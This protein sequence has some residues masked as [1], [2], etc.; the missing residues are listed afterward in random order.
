MEE[1]TNKT[2]LI[3]TVVLVCVAAV[4][5]TLTFL[6][7]FGV[8]GGNNKTSGGS[9]SV[10]VYALI[11]DYEVDGT[12]TKQ[13]TGFSFT[14]TTDKVADTFT[15]VINY[16]DENKVV[17][18]RAKVDKRNVP[19]TVVSCGGKTLALKSLDYGDKTVTAVYA[20]A[21]AEGKVTISN[22]VVTEK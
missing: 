18:V 16:D 6:Y 19:D 14:A 12:L 10:R 2:R 8:F 13:E 4:A 5:V 1:K 9:Q 7:M 15:V 3:I 21:G 17:S 11:K 22:F 20:L